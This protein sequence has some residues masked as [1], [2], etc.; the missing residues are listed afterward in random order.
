MASKKRCCA[1]E[2]NVRERILAASREIFGRYSFKAASTRMVARKAGVEH[3]MI[4]YYFGSKEKLF[5]TMAAE[6]YAGFIKSME[7]WLEGLESMSPRKGLELFIDRMLDFALA[8]PDA[9]QVI[10]LNMV[11]IGGIEEIPGY[12]YIT[13][14]MAKTKRL[15]EESLPLR[16]ASREIEMFIYC[17]SSQMITHIGARSMHAQLLNMEPDGA[18]YRAWVKE[19]SLTLFLPW[20]KRLLVLPD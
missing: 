15:L 19:A 12:R 6:M 3:P 17:F 7:T 20:L 13:L 14:H 10:A 9:L 4:H 8:Q 5:E 1:E 11:H 18:D 2:G 16:G